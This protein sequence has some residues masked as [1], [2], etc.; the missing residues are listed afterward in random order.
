VLAFAA[1]LLGFNSSE[2]TKQSTFELFNTLP[3]EIRDEIWKYALPR[4]R[5]VNIE[6]VRWL[7]RR[8]RVAISADPVTLLGVCKESRRIALKYYPPKLSTHKW[9]PLNLDYQNDIFSFA[10][11]DALRRFLEDLYTYGL[12]IH[13]QEFEEEV[14]KVFLDCLFEDEVQAFIAR[15]RNIQQ[16]VLHF[17]CYTNAL[18]TVQWDK[19]LSN[20][21]YHV[22]HLICTKKCRIIDDRPVVYFMSRGEMKERHRSG[23]GVLLGKDAY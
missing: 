10:G 14:Q 6:I 1:N 13:R 4:N 17:D 12:P 3:A 23:K 7:Q 18:V 22:L 2:D 9:R 16:L 21:H 20:G 11:K 8:R 5:I 15:L 19:F